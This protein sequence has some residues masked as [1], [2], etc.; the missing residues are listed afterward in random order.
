VDV[1]SRRQ[2]I[3]TEFWLENIWKTPIWKPGTNTLIP[4]WTWN[5]KKQVV[6]ITHW[7]NWL[8]MS[9]IG[10]LVF[11]LPTALS[12]C[13]C[14]R[15]VSPSPQEVAQANGSKV[16]PTTTAGTSTSCSGRLTSG[17]W[18]T[19]STALDYKRVDVSQRR[20]GHSHVTAHWFSHLYSEPYMATAFRLI[21]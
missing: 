19:I 10:M 21:I 20:S 16:A 15:S 11:Q 5:M 3:C 7:S 13:Y 17:K 6:R 2:E 4:P 18:A 8:W 9:D 14:S 1:R 12:E